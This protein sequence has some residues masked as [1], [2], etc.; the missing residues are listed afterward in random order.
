MISLLYFLIRIAR[1]AP[2][3]ACVS[4]VWRGLAIAKDAAKASRR[5]LAMSY[6]AHAHASA[7]RKRFA[8]VAAIATQSKTARMHVR[9][10]LVANG[11]G[12]GAR[13]RLDCCGIE[14]G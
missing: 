8:I 13:H 3:S 4:R 1:Q 7:Q 14:F 2:R 6:L 12:C 11:L 5:R 10:R 9:T